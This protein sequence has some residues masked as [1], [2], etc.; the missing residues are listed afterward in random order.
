MAHVAGAQRLGGSGVIMEAADFDRSL[1]QVRAE[2]AGQLEGVFGPNSVI[3]QV[4]RDAL[5]FL[6]AG[7]AL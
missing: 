1:D 6:G 7:R 3:W 4:D 2:A 5:V